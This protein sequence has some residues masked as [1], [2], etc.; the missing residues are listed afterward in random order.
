[1][2]PAIFL[3]L[4]LSTVIISL[5]YHH[6]DIIKESNHNLLVEYT[7]MYC[8]YTEKMVDF[9]H[10]EWNKTPNS[11]TYNNKILEELHS[12]YQIDTNSKKF[13]ALVKEV[14]L[15]IH[16]NGQLSVADIA[17]FD[18]FSYC[19]MQSE[20]VSQEYSDINS[21][22]IEYKQFNKNFKKVKNDFY[23]LN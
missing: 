19:I 1:M 18:Y 11:T 23:I 12:I 2:R 20:L 22:L 21:F 8:E 15:I 17:A 5:Y 9:R 16:D 6:T 10:T 14:F 4:V 13:S 7:K 3:A